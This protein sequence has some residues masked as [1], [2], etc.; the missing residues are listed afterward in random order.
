MVFLTLLDQTVLVP[1][2]DDQ[3]NRR[4]QEDP[5]QLHDQGVVQA[6]LTEG[7]TSGDRVGDFVEGPAGDDSKLWVGQVQ[8]GFDPDLD[9]GEDGSH[10][11]DH[12]DGEHLVLTLAF[13]IG[14]FQLR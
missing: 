9:Q 11:T 3:S 5:G 14:G 4:Q 8:E 13:L 2:A 6:A 10:H 12:C 1:V 7:P